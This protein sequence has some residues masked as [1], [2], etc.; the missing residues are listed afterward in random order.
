MKSRTSLGRKCHLSSLAQTRQ[1][2]AEISRAD[3]AERPDGSVTEL[4][5]PQ[6]GGAKTNPVLQADRLLDGIFI[7]F[8]VAR[9]RECARRPG[10]A[11]CP[12]R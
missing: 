2:H 3:S 4:E 11:V 8:P 9:R 6:K 10:T 5:G 12:W 1:G 7:C